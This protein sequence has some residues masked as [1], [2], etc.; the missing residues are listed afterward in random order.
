LRYEAWKLPVSDYIKSLA[1]GK[2]TQSRFT[3]LTLPP[4]DCRKQYKTHQSPK[5]MQANFEQLQ[6]AKQQ[7][8]KK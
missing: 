7:M 8:V 2:T 5:E 6:A 4:P 1:L 3:S